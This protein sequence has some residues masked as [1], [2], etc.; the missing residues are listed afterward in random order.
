MSEHVK[1]GWSG[2][3]ETQEGTNVTTQNPN[4]LISPVGDGPEKPQTV[5]HRRRFPDRPAHRGDTAEQD[6]IQ[7]NQTLGDFDIALPPTPPLRD[8]PSTYRVRNTQMTETSQTTE[9]SDDFSRGSDITGRDRFRY[10]GTSV[11]TARKFHT[12]VPISSLRGQQCSRP[13][14]K[15]PNKSIS[16]RF[17]KI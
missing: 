11:A 13:T 9:I 3:N 17:R 2:K 4:P 5:Q 14:P 7:R 8:S 1:M 10:T 6:Q 15:S 16:K 12:L